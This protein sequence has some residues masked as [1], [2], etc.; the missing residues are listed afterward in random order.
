MYLRKGDKFFHVREGY[1]KGKVLKN[2]ICPGKG[3]VT[4]IENEDEINNEDGLKNEDDLE[5]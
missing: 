5:N 2:G 3:R 1:K 4:K